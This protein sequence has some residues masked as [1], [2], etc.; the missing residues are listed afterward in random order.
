MHRPTEAEDPGTAPDLRHDLETRLPREEQPVQS[1]G[2]LKTV[3]VGKNR[4]VDPVGGQYDPVGAG[5]GACPKGEL[6]VT[7]GEFVRRQLGAVDDSIFEVEGDVLVPV[8]ESNDLLVGEHRT[9]PFRGCSMRVG[10]DERPG[11]GDAPHHCACDDEN[12][13]PA[14]EPPR[15]AHQPPG[16]DE[17]RWHH[18]RFPVAH[19]L[20]LQSAQSQGHGDEPRKQQREQDRGVV[21]AAG[22]PLS[23]PFC[24]TPRAGG[25][26]GDDCEDEKH[27]PTPECELTQRVEHRQGVGIDANIGDVGSADDHR[28]LAA[29]AFEIGWIEG[30][31]RE[32]HRAQLGDESTAANPDQGRHLQK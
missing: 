5:E 28:N 32:H 27:A 31:S 22:N 7:F 11:V 15:E 17:N 3:R 24:Q 9:E 21:E 14:A 25:A 13:G 19:E 29:N 16:G 4:T 1:R 8:L 10:F 18:Q 6:L 30:A 26:S 2:L 20:D 12:D 23:P